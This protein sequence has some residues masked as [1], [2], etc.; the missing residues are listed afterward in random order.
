MQMYGKISVGRDLW[1][2]FNLT[3]H[4]KVSEMPDCLRLL[5]TLSSQV[6]KISKSGG[7]TTSGQAVS[8]LKYSDCEEL[9]LSFQ[10]VPNMSCPFTVQ[11]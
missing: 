5:S 10:L 8:I 4:Q 1:R 2:L 6:F 9:I 11:L 7:A 3:L